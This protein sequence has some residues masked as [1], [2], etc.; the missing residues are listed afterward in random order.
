MMKLS[1]LPTFIALL[2]L[3]WAHSE[4]TDCCKRLTS[5]LKAHSHALVLDGSRL[6]AT[7]WRSAG[8]GF[9]QTHSVVDRSN[10]TDS[11]DYLVVPLEHKWHF[12]GYIYTGVRAALLM[13]PSRVFELL[14]GNTDGRDARR[15]ISLRDTSEKTHVEECKEIYE[16]FAL[17]AGNRSVLGAGKISFQRGELDF[18]SDETRRSFKALASITDVVGNLMA[19]NWT[20]TANFEADTNRR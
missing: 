13:L 16:C 2:F 12:N 17:A 8:E 19:W 7:T 10:F 20:Y 14:G 18:I 9:V 15:K 4:H 6:W 1:V 5:E 11:F 3:A